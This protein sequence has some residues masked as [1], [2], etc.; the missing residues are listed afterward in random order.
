MFNLV[1]KI[2]KLKRLT[3]VYTVFPEPFPEDTPTV[4]FGGLLY[5]LK[6]LKMST[7]GV[8]P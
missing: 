5:S 7:V 6:S 3:W 8:P 4:H 2:K 1:A